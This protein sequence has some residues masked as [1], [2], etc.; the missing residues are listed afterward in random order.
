ME[1][2]FSKNFL[3][4]GGLLCFNLVLPASK[5][6]ATI[7]LGAD[8][9]GWAGTPRPAWNGSGFT[10]TGAQRVCPV[11][12]GPA[13]IFR[14]SESL[15]GRGGQVWAR[16]RPDFSSRVNLFRVFCILKTV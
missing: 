10:P 3:F 1:Y 8:P 4:V 12:P 16:P 7:V 9:V 11:R 14:E 6:L 2:M 15:R 13:Q 5:D